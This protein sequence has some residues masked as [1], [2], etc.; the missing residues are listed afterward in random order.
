M[1]FYINP[2]KHLPQEDQRLGK[3]APYNVHFSI[4]MRDLFPSVCTYMPGGPRDLAWDP[5]PLASL[6]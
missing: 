2:V 4:Y 5:V 6:A 3:K 1:S